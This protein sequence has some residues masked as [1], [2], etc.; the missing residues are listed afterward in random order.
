MQFDAFSSLIST[1][2]VRDS[3]LM[4]WAELNETLGCFKPA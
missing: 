4:H 2:I 3:I 1:L